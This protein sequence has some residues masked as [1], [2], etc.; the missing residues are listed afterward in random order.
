M[1]VGIGFGALLAGAMFI[2][3]DFQSVTS[4]GSRIHQNFNLVST[5]FRAIAQ[6]KTETQTPTV[7]KAKEKSM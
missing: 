6:E 1:E 2:E 5:D 4:H 3:T 7:E